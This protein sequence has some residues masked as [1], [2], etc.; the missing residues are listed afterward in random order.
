M[1][2][3]LQKLSIG[4]YQ[5]LG[6]IDART[7]SALAANVSLKELTI[8]NL[9]EAA[10]FELA[11]S[12]SL[13]HLT[14]QNRRPFSSDE[15]KFFLNKSLAALAK[16][17]SLTELNYRGYFTIDAD[18]ANVMASNSNLKRVHFDCVWFDDSNEITAP[19]LNILAKA[20]NITDLKLASDNIND[21]E[22]IALAGN[23]VLQRL[24]LES[25][26]ISTKGVYALSANQTLTALTLAI[27]PVNASAYNA[28]LS[29]QAIAIIDVDVNFKT[30]RKHH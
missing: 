29:N 23:K 5:G 26:R 22:T 17:P 4:L 11:K 3:K 13:E 25:S 1:L 6:G 14:I 15:I 30:I 18:V 28:L 16:M 24:S 8:E 10:G 27:N 7:A 21:A 12:S 2:P 20:K 19:A 9:D